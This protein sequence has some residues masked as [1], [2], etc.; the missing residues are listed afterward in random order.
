MRI[1]RY[2][3]ILLAGLLLLVTLACSTSGL[4]GSKSAT[5]ASTEAYPVPAQITP[6]QESATSAPGA[7]PPAAVTESAPYPAPQASAATPQP[8]SVAPVAAT[9]CKEVVCKLNGSFILA[10]PIG[11]NGRNTIDTSARYGTLRKGVG[12]AYHGVQFLNSLGTPVLAA[13][14]GEVVVAGDDSQQLYGPRQNMYGNLVILK[15]T[16]PGIDVPVYTLY[17]HLSELS[18]K[19]GSDVKAGD[20]IGLVGS[21]GSVRGSTLYF[22]VRYG[23]N[24]YDATRNP[25]LW[26]QLLPAETGA[27]S[28]ALA[29][30]IVDEK[31]NPV[32]V[33]NI[34]VK[35]QRAAGMG[36]IRQI[37]LRTY[38]EKD[39]MGTSPWGESFAASDLPEG[40]Y[41]LAF[42]YRSKRYDRTVE[43]QPGMMTF[44][45]FTVK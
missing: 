21:S 33:Q 12:D 44:V 20:Q 15:H 17:A 16:L 18:K 7:Q 32:Q 25:E 8:G 29:G 13:A 37:Y 19:A 31:G 1:P 43:V 35:N 41:N 45:R 40:T 36:Q 4:L 26:L 24:T 6:G 38:I 11:P 22:E 10:R 34:L 5:P 28:G 27:T 39:L 9:A 30:I 23:E 3:T 42:W 2:T 14:D